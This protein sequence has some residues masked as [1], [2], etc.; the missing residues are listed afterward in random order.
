MPTTQYPDALGIGLPS[1]MHRYMMHRYITKHKEAPTHGR[2]QKWEQERGM[3][4]EREWFIEGGDFERGG[5]KGERELE[6]EMG[7]DGGRV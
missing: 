2:G 3:R 6:R 4:R 5:R 7:R 1:L